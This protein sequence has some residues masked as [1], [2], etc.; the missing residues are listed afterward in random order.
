MAD[1]RRFEL[2]NRFSSEEE[3]C[4]PHS[5]IVSK[6]ESNSLESKDRN[7]KSKKQNT[8]S[9]SSWKTNHTKIVQARLKNPPL[10]VRY[11]EVLPML[12]L[13]LL[14]DEVVRYFSS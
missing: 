4:T 11:S 10:T 2:R 14:K 12:L 1:D 7:K 9:T 3:W 13:L 8:S 5:Q 6:M